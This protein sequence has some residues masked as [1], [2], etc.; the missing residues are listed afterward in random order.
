MV[1]HGRRSHDIRPALHGG[2]PRRSRYSN[3]LFCERHVDGGGLKDATVLTSFV[4]PSGRQPAT[5]GGG[6]LEGASPQMLASLFS[7]A[8]ALSGDHATMGGIPPEVS[9]ACIPF[10]APGWTVEGDASQAGASESDGL[11]VRARSLQRTM[12]ATCIGQ[13]VLAACQFA[14]NDGISGLIGCCIGTLGLQASSS[15]GFRLLPSYI[16][17]AFCNG[18]M[19]VLV[20]SELAAS[21]HLIGKISAV[22]GLKLASVVSVVS[23]AMMFFGMVVGWHLHSELRAIALQALPPSM[24]NNLIGAG[25]TTVD[26]VVS[27]ADSA[28]GQGA[29]TSE[30]SG[31]FR[32]FSGQSH[33]LHLEAKLA[34]TAAEAK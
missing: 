4:W 20:G 15:T 14:L 33:R 9:M 12:A 27:A 26:G 24:R 7:T 13:A 32:A 22:A 31:P 25:Q 17:L 29:A 19:Q 16:V 21:H 6:I 1:R 10:L 28:V 3:F 23:P 8:A 18:T 34:A 11:T 2:V 30:L 5:G